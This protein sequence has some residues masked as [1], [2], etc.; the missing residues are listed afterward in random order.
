V[1]IEYKGQIVNTKHYC[2]LSEE[3]CQE[4]RE[5]YYKRPSKELL[6]E[7]IK[8][9]H[10]GGVKINHITNY[11][12]KDIMAKVKMYHSKWS[13]EEVFECDD[14]IR[15]FYAKSAYNK[16][17]YPDTLTDIKKI[18]TALRLGGKGI[19]A[20]PSNFP[21]KTMREL[22]DLY[23]INNHYYDYSCGWGVRLTGALK[24]KVNYYGT[25]PNDI[26]V[27]RLKIY[28][29]AYNKLN[30]TNTFYDIRCQGSEEFI[31]EWE[32]KIGFAFSSPPYFALEDYRVGD[33]QSYKSGVSYNEW[34]N[35]YLKGT[36][37]NIYKYLIN[38]GHLAVNINDYDKYHL[39]QDTR[40]IC[41]D[42]G[43]KYLKC[44]SLKNIKRTNSNGGHNDNSEDIMIFTKN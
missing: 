31:S 14:L 43:F 27:K 37:K 19:A 30:K 2:E 10:N 32:N 13:I 7:Q 29:N 11:F 23:N 12:F 41:E 28:A 22:F 17:V 42:I 35:G 38:D 24:E 6:K 21:L 16:K 3:K 1:K 25:D 33:K 20:K 26:L 15:F 40:K 8:K 9:V 36:M 44:H 34:L 5:Q 18:E 39:V 4:L